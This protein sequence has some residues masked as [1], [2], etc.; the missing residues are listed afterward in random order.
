M[1]AVGSTP[2]AP[3]YNRS[4]WHNYKHSNAT[5]KTN[6]INILKVINSGITL[7]TMQL[8]LK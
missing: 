6:F 8:K 3:F 5:N 1:A 2:Q 4:L 7:M